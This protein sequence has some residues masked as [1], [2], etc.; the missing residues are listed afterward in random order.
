MIFWRVHQNLLQ[1]L[2]HCCCAADLLSYRVHSPTAVIAELL[3]CSA[4]YGECHKMRMLSTKYHVG[5]CEQEAL[6]SREVSDVGLC[7]I[8]DTMRTC[9]ML[10]PVRQFTFSCTCFRDGVRCLHHAH[11]GNEMCGRQP[12]VVIAAM[13]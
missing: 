4:A 9:A 2:E 5:C 1:P 7:Y 8:S 6:Q 3:I 12:R 10:T 13:G 11:L